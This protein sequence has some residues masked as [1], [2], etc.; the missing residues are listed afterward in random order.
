MAFG[1]AYAMHVELADGVKRV[2]AFVYHTLARYVHDL[3][4]VE[5]GIKADADVITVIVNGLGALTEFKEH[6]DPNGSDLPS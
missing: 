2:N 1:M 4:V 3:M 6:E 5:S